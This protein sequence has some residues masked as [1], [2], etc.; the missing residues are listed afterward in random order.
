MHVGMSQSEADQ[1]EWRGTD[2][3]GELKEKGLTY[4][5][6]PNI[7]ANNSTGFSGRPGGYRNWFGP[8]EEKGFWG[9]W[10]TS[11]EYDATYAWKR[12]LNYERT[13][14]YNYYNPKNA[15]FSVRCIKN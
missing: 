5:E 9:I 3:G 14:I 11:T 10:W 12:N 4:W 13:T 1:L 15:G 7:G 2:E 6:S 8:Y